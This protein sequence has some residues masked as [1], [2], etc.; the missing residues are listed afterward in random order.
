M[1]AR[2]FRAWWLRSRGAI[3]A[4]NGVGYTGLN[5]KHYN[6]VDSYIAATP[7]PARGMLEHIR[8]LVRSAAP[9]EAVERIS[10]GIPSFYYKGGLVAYG[11]FTKHC[12]F[13]PMGSSVLEGL[14]D[15]VSHYRISKG[16]LH[17]A[18]DKR[19]PATLIKKIVKARVA[20]N[21][22][23]VERKTPARKRSKAAPARSK[24]TG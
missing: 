3:I 10:Y 13:F 1:K 4:V 18:F 14:G 12:S 6:D 7:E 5:V 2:I 23:R 19:L 11:A 8:S 21:V 16:T 15:E 17:F 9:A 22:A 20:Q 24:R